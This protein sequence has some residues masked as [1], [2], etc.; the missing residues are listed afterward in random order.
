M[1]QKTLNKIIGK[2]GT[3][4]QACP[5]P[6]GNVIRSLIMGSD[7][8]T[9]PEPTLKCYVLEYAM[10][11]PSD[12]LNAITDGSTFSI[13]FTIALDDTPYNI[14]AALVAGFNG[15]AIPFESINVDQ[16]ALGGGLFAV[17]ITFYGI[18]YDTLIANVAGGDR[19]LTETS[20]DVD[21]LQDSDNENILDSLG[22]P[23]ITV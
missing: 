11:D 13:P 14:Y 19:I 21:Y 15:D 2:P 7:E 18:T 8:T 6:P 17:V 3:K 4:S 12:E 9:P 16:S 1:N 22:L 5:C 20:C 10:T 23:L